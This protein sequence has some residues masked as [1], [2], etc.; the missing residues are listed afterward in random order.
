MLPSCDVTVLQCYRLPVS[1]PPVAIR[2]PAAL[3]AGYKVD[4]KLTA[5]SQALEI[6]IE[7]PPQAQ[8]A[9]LAQGGSRSSAAT[10]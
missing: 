2:D 4:A 1:R 3:M 8:F 7:L 9:Q 5:L 6:I 10:R